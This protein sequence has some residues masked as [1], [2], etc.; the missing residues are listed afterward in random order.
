MEPTLSCNLLCPSSPIT[1]YWHNIES[2]P[3]G[4][5][6]SEV[7]L[8][9]MNHKWS[10]LIGTVFHEYT[11]MFCISFSSSPKLVPTLPASS[12][13]PDYPQVYCFPFYSLPSFP[14]S[15]YVIKNKM[16]AHFRYMHSLLYICTH[17][18]YRVY[19]KACLLWGI[20]GIFKAIPTIHN[21]GFMRC[22]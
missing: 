2:H 10:S 3:M 18:H 19:A 5:S 1:C 7:Y 14:L 17:T 16:I 11:S 15:L 4:M 13:T 6:I 22:L 9:Q 8:N 21:F 12:S 20:Q